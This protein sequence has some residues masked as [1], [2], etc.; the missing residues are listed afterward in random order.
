MNTIV[1]NVVS[2][3]AGYLI[4]TIDLLSDRV[5]L[6]PYTLQQPQVRKWA[7]G[8]LLI[9]IALARVCVLVNKSNLG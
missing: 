9:K 7:P 5:S 2:S 4:K 3:K 6:S 1:I 8:A